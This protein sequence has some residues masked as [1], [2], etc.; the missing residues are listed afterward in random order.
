MMGLVPLKEEEETPE[1]P[2]S[3]P[4][5]DTAYLQARKRA[6]AKNRIGQNPD[7]GLPASRTVRG[8]YLLFEPPQ[9]RAGQ[10]D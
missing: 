4:R 6:L 1:V 9:P 8:K 10:A 7:V 3:P 5:E 2:L